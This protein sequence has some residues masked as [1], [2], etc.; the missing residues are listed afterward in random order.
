[1][2]R[3]LWSSLLLTLLAATGWR[4]LKRVMYNSSREVGILT[5]ETA[6][7]RGSK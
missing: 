3:T 1:M 2:Y 7:L 5:W 6:V 4:Y